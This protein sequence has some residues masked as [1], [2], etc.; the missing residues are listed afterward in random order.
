MAFTYNNPEGEARKLILLFYA[1]GGAKGRTIPPK[2]RRKTPSWIYI[3]D[4]KCAQ[5][6]GL[7]EDCF[8]MGLQATE[9]DLDGME[10][11]YERKQ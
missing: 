5:N 2:R 10:P 11:N 9:E 8:R 4:N 7:I 3:D 1:N 6:Y